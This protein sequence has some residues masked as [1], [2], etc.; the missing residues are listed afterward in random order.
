MRVRNVCLKNRKSLTPE[1]KPSVYVGE[2][3][4][5]PS[6]S[7]LSKMLRRPS[8][9][10][11]REGSPPPPGGVGATGAAGSVQRVRKASMVRQISK[12]K[13]HEHLRF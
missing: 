5:S 2:A 8:Q 12:E 4:P 13:L 1:Q 9:V 10:S 7:V 6:P 3:K 11:F